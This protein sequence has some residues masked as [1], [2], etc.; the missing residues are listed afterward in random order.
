MT[1]LD[2]PQGLS[3]VEDDLDAI[4]VDTPLCTGRVYFHGA[5]IASWTPKGAEPVIWLS[6]HSHFT[7]DSAIRGG[8]PVCFPWFGP[9]RSGD[10]TPA[11]GPAR[12]AEWTLVDAARLDTGIVR[13]RFTLPQRVLTENGFADDA[14]VALHIAMGRSL[15]IQ[16]SVN[17]GS[18]PC[19][20][21]EALHT[22]LHVGDIS[23]LRIEG[24]EGANYLDKVDNRRVKTQDGAVVITDETDRIYDSQENLR[25]VD[26]TLGRTIE[27]A[28][29]GSA[30]TVV[31]NP[32][33]DKAA[34]MSDFGDDEWHTMVCVE[35]V[36]ALSNQVHLEAGQ[37]HVMSQ[38][39]TI[40]S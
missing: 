38:M 20:F 10:K 35:A 31:W 37:K 18:G 5:H 1:Q 25:L 30:D 27:V 15:Q 19:V 29:A 6:D 26:P 24:L 8:V 3:L 39:I 17:A 9:G 14:S 28:K 36:N 12:L 33:A 40:A 23:T 4:D 21:E 22:Y 16:L 32:W 13:M 34:A 2:L 11:H 7:A